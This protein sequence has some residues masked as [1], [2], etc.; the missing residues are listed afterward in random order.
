MAQRGD[1]IGRNH[2]THQGQS[3]SRH[4]ASSLPLQCLLPN[5]F[6]KPVLQLQLHSILPPENLTTKAETFKYLS[7]QEMKYTESQKLNSDDLLKYSVSFFKM[8][9]V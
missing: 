1:T 3:R 5:C 2:I 6:S 4:E 8:E 9:T 7:F